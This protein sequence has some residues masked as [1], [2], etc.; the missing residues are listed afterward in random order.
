LIMPIVLGSIWI[1]IQAGRPQMSMVALWSSFAVT[2]AGALASF[3]IAPTMSNVFGLDRSGFRA[4]V[5]LPTQRHYILL[6]KNLAFFPFVATISLLLMGLLIGFGRLSW[7]LLI[8]GI[9]QAVAGF[10]LFCLGCNL[11]SI[12]FPYRLS[13]NSLQAKRP[14]PMVVLVV[15]LSMALIPLAMSPILLPPALELLFGSMSWAP[16]LPVNALAA[17]LLMVL[18]AAL[19]RMVL[20][21][22]GRLLLQREKA[23]LLEVTEEVE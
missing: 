12:L 8:P 14:K 20:P 4:L 15:F 23:I 11:L 13:P 16:W 7:L 21:W 19:Y 17:L 5:L 2:G 6:A 9:L 10:L 3:S 18:V 22:Q 1:S